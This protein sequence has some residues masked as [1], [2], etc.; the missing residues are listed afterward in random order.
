MAQVRGAMVAA[1][2]VVVA[3][4][5]AGPA[6][7]ATIAPDT[8]ADDFDLFPDRTCSLREA[9]ESANREENFG[10]CTAR[11]FYDRETV[12][13]R[14]GRYELTLGPGDVVGSDN[15][16][17]DLDVIDPFQV[18]M[19][20]TGPGQVTIDANRR[21]RVAEVASPFATLLVSGITLRGG[22]TGEDGGAV[23]AAG[24]MVLSDSALVDSVAG[25]SGGGLALTSSRK[26]IALVNTTVSGNVAG[27]SG[28][29]LAV[30]GGGRAYLT[31]V[32]T[33]VTENLARG[34]S[35]GGGH[36]GGL[37][38]GD[39]LSYLENSILAGNGVRGGATGPDCAGPNL[40]SRGGNLIGSLEGCGALD[41]RPTDLRGVPAGV[42]PLGNYGG[43]ALSHALAPTSAALNA[44]RD[45]L[46]ATFDGRGVPRRLGGPCDIGAYER[47]RCRGVLV[48]RVGTGKDDLLAGTP[49]RDGVLAL[50]GDDFVRAGAGRD[51][52][53]G[54]A[55]EDVLRGGDGADAL[56]GQRGRDRCL[57]RGGTD[58]ADGC[59]VLRGVP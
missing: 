14:P 30:L 32:N 58:R 11:G 10:G 54:G 31:L 33:T 36:G 21:D 7:A 37:A 35:L 20:A 13:V 46:C 55:G 38:G 44:A 19:I 8:T 50:N 16:T 12:I 52:V 2:G 6:A 57:G 18:S 47:V 51:A 59:E 9:I 28:G 42:R 56:A 24:R 29:G 17:G 15:A 1:V 40:I 22:R 34:M 49:G 48:D 3:L 39:G 45:G 23:L 5:A 27:G 53:C 4:L 26:G 25:G 41:P 43:S